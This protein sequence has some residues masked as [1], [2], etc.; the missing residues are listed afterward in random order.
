MVSVF[1]IGNDG[2]KCAFHLPLD[3]A[4]GRENKLEAKFPNGVHL[5]LRLRT[6]E[7]YIGTA[8]SVARAAAIKR[9]TE[10]ERFLWDVLNA[11]ESAPWKPSPGAQRED[12][13]APAAR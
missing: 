6:N 8:T 10:P 3:R 9:K 13:Q 12:D 11:V 4:R 2:K 1:D 7:M 5:G